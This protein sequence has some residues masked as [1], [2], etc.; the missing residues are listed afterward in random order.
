MAKNF[1]VAEEIARASKG[2]T[3]ALAGQARAVERKTVEVA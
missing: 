3:G 1:A 2:N